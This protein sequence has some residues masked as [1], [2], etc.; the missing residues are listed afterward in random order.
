MSAPHELLTRRRL[1]RATLARQ[2][3]LQR[4][5]GSAVVVVER[6]CGVQAQ[7]PRPPFPGLWTRLRG[8]RHQDLHR[9]LHDRRIVRGTLMRGTLHLMSAADYVAHRMTLQPM[10][11]RS[12]ALLGARAE[13]L[14][15]EE[16]LPVARTLLGE[17]PRTFG[18]LRQA[19]VEAFPSIN[20]RALGFTV[21]MSLPLV[22]IP[23]EDR[24]GFPADS[25]FGLA[26]NWL[27]MPIAQEADLEALIL[28]YLAAFGP[29]TS[30]DVQQWSGLQG[31]KPVLES[32]RPR[33]ALFHDERGRTLFD[34]PNAPRPAEG[35]PAPPRFLPE[36]DN[37]LLSHADRTRA[38]ADEHRH[39]I[40]GAKNG[41]I[42]A[43]FLVD[44]SVAGTWRVERKKQAATLT[45]T[46]FTP[47]P[48]SVATALGEE[49]DALLRFVEDDAATCEVRQNPPL[50]T[51]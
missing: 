19:L 49:G 23:T 27:G 37:L 7:E 42:P 28:R 30:A 15:A 13:G 2:M 33:L 24:W 8:F 50:S 36:F 4:E 25:R 22:M 48:K 35:T 43:T 47:L 41:R 3:L 39:F 9:A 10:L 45:I 21:R 1:N 34:L 16:V 38:L 12:L 6:I 20:D 44:G 46:P 11:T 17:R 14:Q 40:L 26:E 32:L 29:A 18:E 5:R 51:V 31:I